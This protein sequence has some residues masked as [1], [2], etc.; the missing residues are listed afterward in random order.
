MSRVQRGAWWILAVVAGCSGTVPPDAGTGAGMDGGMDAMDVVAP[1]DVGM[2]DGRA[3]EA[4][5]SISVEFVPTA[6]TVVV[7]G[8][9]EVATTDDCP[10]AEAVAAVEVQADAPPG[11]H[12]LVRFATRC[13]AVLLDWTSVQILPV[14]RVPATGARGT[15]PAT[16]AV[17][18]LE[19]PTGSLVAGFQV[20]TGTD[21]RTLRALALRCVALSRAGRSVVVADPVQQPAVGDTAVGMQPAVDC[22]AGTVAR[23]VVLRAGT[24]IDALGLRCGRPQVS[25]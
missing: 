14:D 18:T 15:G 12:T 3:P 5:L 20:W 13:D 25:P 9:T 8:G 11:N 24:T 10:P 19:C 2:T 17:T 21:G 16:G 1:A 7:G 4:G 22:G 6:D 23:G